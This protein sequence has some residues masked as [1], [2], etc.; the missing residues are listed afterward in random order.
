MSQPTRRNFA[1]HL[2]TLGLA[3]MAAAAPAPPA[4]DTDC[5]PIHELNLP[6]EVFADLKSFAEPVLEQ[7][8]LLE[9]LPLAGLDFAFRFEP[10]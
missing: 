5:L 3:P 7:V 8:R 2:G 1:R 4:P 9:E 6:P 10:K